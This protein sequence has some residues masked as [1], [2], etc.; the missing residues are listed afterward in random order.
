MTFVGEIHEIFLSISA[1]ICFHII[2]FVRSNCNWIIIEDLSWLT[3]N[4]SINSDK[5]RL[6]SIGQNGI[7]NLNKSQ[8]K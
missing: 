6:S 2:I 4:D 1:L 7:Q 8:T 3:W 5:L